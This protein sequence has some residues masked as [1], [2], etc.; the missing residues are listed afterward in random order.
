MRGSN[1]GIYASMRSKSLSRCLLKF[2]ERAE[3]KSRCPKLGDPANSIITFS[4]HV[5]KRDAPFPLRKALRGENGGMENG[6]LDTYTGS[7]DR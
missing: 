2:I 4:K 5:N 3:C 6:A 7:L 1:S